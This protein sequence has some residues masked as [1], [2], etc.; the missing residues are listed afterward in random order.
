MRLE[1]ERNFAAGQEV[2]WSLLH[3]PISVKQLLP[4]CDILTIVSSD[5]YRGSLSIRIGQVVEQYDGSL[6]LTPIVPGRSFSFHAEGLNPDGAVTVT[7]RVNLHADGPE[8][9]RLVYEADFSVD[10]RPAMV[11]DR[12][13][14]TTARSFARRSLDALQ[15]QVEI[16]TRTYT[17]TTAQPIPS[18]R[19]LSSAGD[20]EKNMIRQ[21]IMAV[22]SVLLALL[23]WRAV[24]RRRNALP[25]TGADAQPTTPPLVAIPHHPSPSRVDA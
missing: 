13:L 5:E 23:V 17:T 1:G 4:G 9:T 2:V 22:L 8:S 6:R 11:A 3:D 19:P 12:M 21:R 20:V 25:L 10:G 24:S 7:G 16:R 14:L 18:L 15:R